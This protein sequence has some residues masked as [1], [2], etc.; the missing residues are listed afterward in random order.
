M[1]SGGKKYLE[2]SPEHLTFVVSKGQKGPLNETGS[3]RITEGMPLR[4]CM[5]IK[6]MCFFLKK[7]L[8]SI[9]IGIIFVLYS[10]ANKKNTPCKRILKIS[11]KKRLKCWLTP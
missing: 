6:N 2:L 10:K 1:C 4:F 9:I 3:A 11:V 8:D 5:V 7:Y